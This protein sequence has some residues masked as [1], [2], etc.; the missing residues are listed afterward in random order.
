MGA[1]WGWTRVLSLLSLLML[2]AS[3]AGCLLG[4][5]LLQLNE[6]A[7]R[8]KKEEASGGKPV[9]L[10]AWEPAALQRVPGRA[11]AGVGSVFRVRVYADDQYRAAHVRWQEHIRALV[12]AG[13]SYVDAGFGARL[14][15]ESIRPW[16]RQ[17]GE[18]LTEQLLRSLQQA[19]AGDDVDWVVGFVAPLGFVTTSIHEIG[20]ASLLGKHLVMR[21]ID[22]REEAAALA[23]HFQGVDA[24]QRDEFLARRRQH[25]ELVV[26][27][28][29]WLHNLGAI[30]HVDREMLMHPSYDNRQAGV[31][32]ENAA[33]V[34][35]ALEARLEGRNAGKAPDHSR[36]RAYL[37][38][39][40]PGTWFTAEREQ[41]LAIIPATP[42]GARAARPA[43]PIEKPAEPAAAG[44][45]VG[46]GPG[47]AWPALAG[48][49]APAGLEGLSRAVEG[50]QW[51]SAIA[52][53]TGA[54]PGEAGSSGEWFARL[55]ELCARAG[56]ITVAEQRLSAGALGSSH[57]GAAREAIRAARAHYGVPPGQ[58]A[59]SPEDEAARAQA[60][61]AVRA[62]L[63]GDRLD[64]ADGALDTALGRFR[65]DAGLLAL[66]CE[67]VV[68]RRGADEGKRGPCE[69]ALT[70]FPDMPRALFWAGLARANSGNRSLA[71][72]RLRRAM[73]LDPAFDGP[74]KVL[75]DIYRFEGRKAELETLRSEH[76]ARFGRPLR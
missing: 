12:A 67:A 49:G 57:E 75:A 10:E 63:D 7:K 20:M 19:D 37:A 62:A 60:W 42:A 58:R 68:R 21:G 25:K 46:P 39:T 17:G 14:E 54:A 74:W 76:Q 9:D 18:A 26:F 48:V 32:P 73:T 27:I 59:R 31:D 70:A 22:D 29:E 34:R 15:I 52:G 30:H 43:A 16:N 1:S 72:T 64:Q 50:K 2:A 24:R 6:A 56:M 36:L 38:T 35:L 23:K 5:D 33:L 41:L 8:R 3:S 51:D 4:V 47:L 66:R 55:S 40:E 13:S 11:G 69:R 53:C 61:F 44:G 65:D 71:V 28:H 45:G